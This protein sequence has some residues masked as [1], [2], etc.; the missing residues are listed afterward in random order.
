M[1]GVDNYAAVRRFVFVEGHSRR[2]A[3]RVGVEAL[4]IDVL[5][6]FSCGIDV[7]CTD[8]DDRMGTSGRPA[9]LLKLVHAPV[10]PHVWNSPVIA[11]FFAL[12][13]QGRITTWG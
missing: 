7:T 11:P 8:D 5:P 2:E 4:A 10:D 13:D 9:N 12:C 6:V 3:A 1:F